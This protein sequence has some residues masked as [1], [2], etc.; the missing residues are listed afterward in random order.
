M[1]QRVP[2]Q[3]IKRPDDRFWILACHPKQSYIAAGHDTGMFVFK[4]YRERPAFTVD[5][6]F[7]YYTKGK[8]VPAMLVVLLLWAA[9]GVD[10]LNVFLL[11]LVSLYPLVCAQVSTQVLVGGE[12]RGFLHEY[13]A[14]KCAFYL[15]F[16]ELQPF[17]QHTS[18]VAGWWISLAVHEWSPC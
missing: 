13:S 14:T 15:L 7:L 11:V 8:C 1:T 4:M 3:T 16:H 6:E 10:I 12:G 9:R 5:G 18:A 2:L 17:P